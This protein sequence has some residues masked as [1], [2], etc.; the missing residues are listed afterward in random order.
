MDS[1]KD[2]RIGLAVNAPWGLESR[3]PEGWVGRYHALNSKMTSMN[4]TPMVAH[5][6]KGGT[7]LALGLQFQQIESTLG[8]AIDFGLLGAK[9]FGGIPGTQ[10]GRVELKADDW[11]TGFVLGLM[12]ESDPKTR[13]GMSYRSAV[14]MDLSGDAR[15]TFDSAGTGQKIAAATGAFKDVGARAD[16]DTPAIFGFGYSRDVGSRWT[17]MADAVR[18]FWGTF[19]ELRITFDNPSQADAVT[20]E[21]W[22]DT[23]FLSLGGKYRANEHWTWRVG[24][25]R[26]EGPVGDDRRIPRIPTSSSRWLALG[27]TWQ[28]CKDVSVDFGWT[29]LWYDKGTIRLSVADPN[30][31]SAGNLFGSYDTRLDILGLSVQSRF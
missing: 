22:H 31:Q 27:A 16:L 6:F 3:Q 19:E 11:G 28:A 18:T 9:A 24:V 26:D 30:N 4:L 12:H 25:A 20:R 15:F 13:W 29:H 2:T 8:N 5:R 1:G 7:S 23:W 17:L 21:E 10:D 14:S